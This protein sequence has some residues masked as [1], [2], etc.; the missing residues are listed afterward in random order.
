MKPFI[1]PKLLFILAVF[2]FSRNQSQKTDSVTEKTDSGELDRT[3]LPI[4]EPPFGGKIGETYKDSKEE[5]PKLVTPPQGVPNVIII[6]LDDV[7]FGQVSTF[8]GPVPTPELDKLADKRF[9]I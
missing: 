4:P 3:I 9:K 8:G 1:S 5:W 6:L 7:G 2:L